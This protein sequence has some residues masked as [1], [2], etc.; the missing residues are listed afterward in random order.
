MAGFPVAT[1]TNS[2]EHESMQSSVGAGTRKAGTP[3]R[4]CPACP[5]LH[6]KSQPFLLTCVCPGV[7]SVWVEAW[8]WGVRGYSISPIQTCLSSY[9]RSRIIFSYPCTPC[10]PSALGWARV[11]ILLNIPVRYKKVPLC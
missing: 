10:Q 3:G 9:C 7:S 8:S 5:A 1:C 2:R 6:K 11:C 4:F